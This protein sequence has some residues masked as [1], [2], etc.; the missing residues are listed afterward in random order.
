MLTDLLDLAARMLELGGRLVY[1]LPTTYDFTDEDLPRHPCLAA[2]ANSEQPLNQKMGRRL[3]TMAKVAEYDDG[4]AAA[5]KAVAEGSSARPFAQLR[6]RM[7]GD[8]LAG[9][10]D[11]REAKRRKTAAAAATTTTSSSVGE[12]QAAAEVEAS[13]SAST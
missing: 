13:A 4:Q 5:Y 10:L 12:G 6:E 2:V 7:Q 9:S 1:L 3:I 8:E 11:K